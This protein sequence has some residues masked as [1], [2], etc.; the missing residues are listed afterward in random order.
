MCRENTASRR[1][2]ARM[3]VVLHL[4]AGVL[5]IAG[6]STA[7]A[8]TV[9]LFDFALNT[10]T[11]ISGDWA[12]LGA[13]DPTLLLNATSSIYNSTNCCNDPG[14]STPGLG[15]LS[16]NFLGAPGSYTVSMY[17]DFDAANPNFNEYG[18]VLGAAAAQAGITYEIFNANSKTSN[19]V[20]YGATG[21]SDTEVYG[22]AD[23]T[24]HVPG[25]T[26]NFLNNC[27]VAAVCNADVGMALTYSFTLATGEYAVLSAVA[28]TTDPG[29]FRLETTH[30]VDANNSVAS[31]IFLT[32]SY[33]I[34]SNPPPPPPPPGTPE[35]STWL[36]L[37]TGL[38]S[39]VFINRRKIRGVV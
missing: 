27:V 36:S 21:I 26:D 20:L 4:S 37:V 3:K 5:L 32:G 2:L 28:S 29:G 12:D 7:R 30:P 10:S 15:A 11:N 17:F 39:L 23:N 8:G 25:T 24:N 38:L 22:N 1:W 13:A 14:G 35:P 33:S 19:I 9:D 16:Y 34:D 31:N 18:T 6:M